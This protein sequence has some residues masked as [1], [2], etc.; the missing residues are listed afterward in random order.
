MIDVPALAGRQVFQI[1]FVVRDF[2]NALARF[3]SVL[4]AGPWRCWTFGSDD[5][6]ETFYRGAPANFSLLLALNGSTPQLELIQPLTGSSAH[7]EWLERHGEGPHHV[8]IVVDSV[9]ETIKQM[10]A[11]GF[12]LIHRGARFGPR[13]DGAWA[14]FDTTEALGLVLEAVE[15]P[16]SMPA[17]DFVW[18]GPRRDS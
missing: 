9:D 4:G 11:A 12:E 6:G 5:H 16:T 14:Y 2:E 18:P 3:S 15:P 17:V 7:Q 13:R 10:A 8:G 1:A